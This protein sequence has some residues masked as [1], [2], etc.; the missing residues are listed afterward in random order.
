MQSR[1]CPPRP[2]AE[3]SDATSCVRKVVLTDAFQTCV[4]MQW[5]A[6]EIKQTLPCEAYFPLSVGGAVTV[7]EYGHITDIWAGQWS[8]WSNYGPIWSCMA[9]LHELPGSKKQ[10]SRRR[11][12]YWLGPCQ[13]AKTW[14]NGEKSFALIWWF[15]HQTALN[16]LLFFLM[17]K[18]IDKFKNKDIYKDIKIYIK[19]YK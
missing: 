9:E 19:I 12:S 15:A 7:N 10:A 18:M 14:L 4:I 2:A 3:D 5:K 17:V 11:C 1:P 8:Y 6:H 13:S 16:K